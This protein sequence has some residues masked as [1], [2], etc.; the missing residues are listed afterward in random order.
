VDNELEVIRHQMEAK[1]ASLA[2]KLDALENQVLG[3]VHETTAE[4]SNIVQDVKSTV[5]TVVGD[6][7]SAADSVSEGVAQTVETVKETIDIR[8]HIRKHPWLAMGGAVAAGFAGAWMLGR[9]RPRSRT[10]RWAYS[11]WASLSSHGEAFTSRPEPPG[12]AERPPPERAP[13]RESTSES[14]L[15]FLGEAGKEVLN[16]VKGMAIGTL[17]GVLGEVVTRSL[18][19]G[20]KSD[21]AGVV[22][23]LTTRLG[24]KVLDVHEIVD[25]FT[26]RGEDHEYGDTSEMGRPMGSTQRPGQEPLGQPD[27]QRTETGRGGLRADARPAQRANGKEP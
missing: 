9:A 26:G 27:R 11:P 8:P 2:D 21:A 7:K 5:E 17:M 14:A 3:T 16:K 6:V 23:D 20:L 1:R 18:P 25:S 19:Q 24:G 4:V 22:R 12:A 10:S 13:E 15:S